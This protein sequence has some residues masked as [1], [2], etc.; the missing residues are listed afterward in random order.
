MFLSFNDLIILL[1]FLNLLSCSLSIKQHFLWW[2]W[3]IYG[4]E[5]SL[6]L[7]PKALLIVN[8]TLALAFSCRPFD[9]IIR[10]KFFSSW[11]KQLVT[12]FLLDLNSIGTN[13]RWRYSLSHIFLLCF[14]TDQTTEVGGGKGIHLPL[15]ECHRNLKAKQ[16]TARRK[17]HYLVALVR[18][19]G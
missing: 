4:P 5:V 13:P 2:T 15:Y 3:Q 7:S 18:Q 19:D 6:V 10:T 8:S 11:Y 1:T 12:C 16:K 14:L 9:G 17:F